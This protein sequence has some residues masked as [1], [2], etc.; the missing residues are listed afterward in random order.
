MRYL[1]KGISTLEKELKRWT[2]GHRK[3]TIA[4]KTDVEAT[5]GII[6]ESVEASMNTLEAIRNASEDIIAIPT[7]NTWYLI[8]ND[9]IAAHMMDM[10]QRA[11]ESVILS[12]LSSEGLNTKLLSKIKEPKIKVLIV[13]ESEEPVPA[14]ESLKGWR[15]WETDSPVLLSIIDENEIVIGGSDVSKQPLAVASSDASY[16]RLYHDIIG[17]MLI[18]QS[19]R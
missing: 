3:S 12:V 9:E 15:I 19:K 2:S 1:R 14:L 17:P 18:N 8:G 4:L 7:E 5:L 16:L 13:P 6:G 11:K 10:A